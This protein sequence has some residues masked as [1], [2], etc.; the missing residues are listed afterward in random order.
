MKQQQDV[1]QMKHLADE[2]SETPDADSLTFIVGERVKV[3]FGPFA[4]FFGE[5]TEVLDD[6]KKLKIL[7]KVFGRE[8]SMEVDFVQ[9]EKESLS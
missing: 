9:V 6:R 8:T 7:V 3:V 5:V 2:L 4:G 1:D